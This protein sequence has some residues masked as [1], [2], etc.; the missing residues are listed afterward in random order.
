[1]AYMPIKWDGFFLVR[2]GDTEAYCVSSISEAARRIYGE[3]PDATQVLEIFY[4]APAIDV[5]AS[6]TSH[7]LWHWMDRA[8]DDDLLG[9]VGVPKFV[10][11]SI[12][13]TELARDTLGEFN[14][15]RAEAENERALSCPRATGRI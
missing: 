12:S 14:R 15:R 11:R 8:S 10:E 9:E 13:A 1:M 5:T 2:V 3:W 6:A 7:V 4:T